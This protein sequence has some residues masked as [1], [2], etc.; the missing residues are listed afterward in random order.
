[1]IT[2]YTKVYGEGKMTRKKSKSVFTVFLLGIEIVAMIF[3]LF[4]KSDASNPTADKKEI[5]GWCGYGDMIYIDC[6]AGTGDCVPRGC[7]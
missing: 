3:A 7:H 6:V 1:M 2:P 4:S 5:V